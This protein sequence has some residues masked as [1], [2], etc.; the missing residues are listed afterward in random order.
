M[1]YLIGIAVIIITLLIFNRAMSIK[2]KN[3][4]IY[5]EKLHQKFQREGRK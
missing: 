4:K 2:R 1:T 3:S 5:R